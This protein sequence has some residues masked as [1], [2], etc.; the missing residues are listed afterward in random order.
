MTYKAGKCITDMDFILYEP[1]NSHHLYHKLI[2]VSATY[3]L[4]QLQLRDGSVGAATAGAKNPPGVT[5]VLTVP[6]TCN[7]DL[8][9]SNW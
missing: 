1:Y 4:A 8:Q 7:D 9:L 5:A 3:V 2:D 6:S